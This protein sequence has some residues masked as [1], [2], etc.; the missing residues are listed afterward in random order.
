MLSHRIFRENTSKEK[1]EED[2]V[3]NEWLNVLYLIKHTAMYDCYIA[4]CFIMCA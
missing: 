1:S 3:A 4:V 2:L